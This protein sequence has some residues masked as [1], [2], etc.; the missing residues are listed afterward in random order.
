M[1]VITNALIQ[2]INAIGAVLQAIILVIGR[3][4]I[5]IIN[6]IGGLFQ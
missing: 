1:E 6:A 4:I 2:I 5:E 3:V